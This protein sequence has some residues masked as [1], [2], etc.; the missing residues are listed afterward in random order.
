MF[1]NMD[2]LGCNERAPFELHLY[3]NNEQFF[4]AQIENSLYI[5]NDKII[6]IFPGEKIYVE[7][8]ILNNEIISLKRVENNENP[9]ITLIIEFIQINE[10]QNHKGM[11]LS[12]KNPFDKIINYSADICLLKYSKW[13]TTDVY[14]IAPCIVG[15][16]IWPDLI[17]SIAL[18]NFCLIDIKE[19]SE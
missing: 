7:A 4:S 3:V 13:V 8:N 10:G 17:S 15:Y 18:S 11:M 12:I 9:E 2:A 6:Q 16:E 19:F 1:A 5:I 14:D